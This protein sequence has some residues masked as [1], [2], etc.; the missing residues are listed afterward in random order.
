MISNHCLRFLR[1]G[2]RKQFRTQLM[3]QKREEL[4]ILKEENP[5]F[6]F[7]SMAEHTLA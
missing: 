7:M 4:M 3:Q 6:S 2:S 1:P 5:E